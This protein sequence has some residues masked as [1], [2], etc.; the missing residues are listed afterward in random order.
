MQG[1]KFIVKKEISSINSTRSMVL[2][3]FSNEELAIEKDKLTGEFCATT[4]LP[5]FRR[6]KV[7]KNIVLSKFAHDIEARA[8]SAL[9][10]RAFDEVRKSAKELNLLTIV[11][12]STKNSETGL[13]CELVFDL[14]PNVELPDYKNISLSPFSDEVSEEEIESELMH[15]KKQHSNYNLVE[16]EVK[17]GDY[18]KVSYYGI[19]DD[20]T[21]VAD[22]VP[23][24]K[25]YG[26]QTNTWEEAG[27]TDVHGVQAVIQGVI[28]H[29][30]GDRCTGKEIF[31]ND[32]S[33]AQLAGKTAIYTFEILE[34][35]ERV[36][37]ELNGEFLS[38]YGVDSVD[39]LKIRICEHFV[40]YKRTQGLARQRDEITHFLANA[41]KFEL[42]GSILEKETQNLVQ[43]FVDSQVRNGKSAKHFEG[44]I[45]EISKS[46]LPTA[47]IRA[48]AGLMLDKIA[49]EEKIEIDNRDIEAMLLQDAAMKNSS[50]DKYLRTLKS[51]KNMLIDL[52][53]RALRG[54]VLDFLVAVNSREASTIEAHKNRKLSSEKPDLV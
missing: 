29:K 13:V 12:F 10:N 26:Q 25:V 35:R 5:G 32:F 38:R 41:A 51:D 48:K 7:P 18:V 8:K 28:G 39:E 53:G 15:I 33:I 4:S 24:H 9:L 14:C 37:P 2:F 49:E 23:G 34:I 44:R 45:E 54:K 40:N 21:A 16:R 50:I 52:R 30:I 43:L 17:V 47:E 6:G 36:D 1:V 3:D 20:G 11:D 46:L 19:F 31:A 42:P 27:N 22:V